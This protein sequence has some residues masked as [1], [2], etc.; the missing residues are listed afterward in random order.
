MGQVPSGFKILLV[1]NGRLAT[2]L[3]NALQGGD[4][5]ASHGDIRRWRR[6]SSFS[7][8]SLSLKQVIREE[9]P[10]H[11][12]LA[13]S[14]TALHDLAEQHREDFK[15]R[16]VV[17]FAGSLSSF[18][19]IH[20]AHP[21]STFSSRETPMSATEFERVPFILDRGAPAF[22]SLFPTLQNASFEMD[23]AMRGYYHALCVMS[24]N[25][26]VLL[27]E[28]AAQR[29]E[30]ELGVPMSAL[31]V[32]REQI[33]KNLEQ[34]SR[35]QNSK[36]VLTGPLARG[37]MKTVDSHLESLSRQKESA[38]LEIYRGFVKLHQE[39]RP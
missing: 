30:H 22:S 39:N 8:S 35:T 14:D 33:F 34:A 5:E 32:Y 10:S 18:S 1:G 29:F 26:T 23:P 21:L 3:F 13:V 24:G 15:G 17:H 11:I 16:T 7:P 20:A 27:W 4:P 2:T 38:L 19:G 12:Y 31:D 36:S 25:F 9:N 6:P 28:A 37:D